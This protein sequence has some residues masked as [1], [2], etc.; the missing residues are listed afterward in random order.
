[1]AVAEANDKCFSTPDKGCVKGIQW[2]KA[3]SVEILAQQV[4]GSPVDWVIEIPIGQI[5]E[6]DISQVSS[7]SRHCVRKRVSRIYLTLTLT[8]SRRVTRPRRPFP[9]ILLR[10]I[11]FSDQKNAAENCLI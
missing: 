8:F 10:N 9:K 7:L 1:M 11:C 3:N 5:S 2:M 4:P 6:D